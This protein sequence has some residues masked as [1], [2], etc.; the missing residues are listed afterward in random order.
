MK[1]AY[2]ILEFIKQK[3]K[4]NL[5]IYI[6]HPWMT[7]LLFTIALEVLVNAINQEKEIKQYE[8]QKGRNK[9]VLLANDT[10]VHIESPYTI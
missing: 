8:Y 3:Q 7:P 5:Y 9:A 10:V 4:Q 6:A 2:P 1:L